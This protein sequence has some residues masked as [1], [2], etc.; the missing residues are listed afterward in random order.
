MYTNCTLLNDGVF[1]IGQMGG[2]PA[3]LF[4]NGGIEYYDRIH[5]FVEKRTGAIVDCLDYFQNKIY[6]L[7]SKE[8]NLAVFDLDNC[9]C[10]YIP[11]GCSHR[12]WMNFSALERYQSDY[13]IFP[14][15][16]NRLLVFDTITNKLCEIKDYLKCSSEI[17]CICRV[18]DSVWV[19]PKD[20]D[21]ICCYHLPN[22]ESKVYKLKRKVENCVHAFF[23][24][25]YIFFLNRYG[26]IYRWD[27]ER[28][29]MYEITVLETKHREEESMSRIICAGN[30]L[31]LLPAYG[32][33]IKILDLLTKKIEIYH[34][35]P[36]DF[37]FESDKYKFYGYCE[38]EMY[39][40]FA[41]CFGN[42]YLKIDKQS[43][44]LV[45]VKPV[46][47]SLGKKAIE[48][49]ENKVFREETFDIEDLLRAGLPKVHQA[50]ATLVGKGIYHLMKA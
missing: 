16:E 18:K 19:L 49:L 50:G 10:H 8:D 15:Y 43:G 48:L 11:L 3:K 27:I 33:D 42:Y 35:Y 13:Y 2:L 26:V 44:L 22:G 46:I 21:I 41:K 29:K 1:L 25:I 24:G 23:D 38:D 39:Y 12:P 9:E 45:W 4:P 17:Q 37:F 14:K 6:A 5:G 36:E 7:D 32:K 40:I 20:T 34:D 30:K 47:S 31:I 28:A